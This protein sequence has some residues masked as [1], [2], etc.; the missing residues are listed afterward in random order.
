MMWI[1]GIVCF[2]LGFIIASMLIG[3]YAKENEA[4]KE[5]L[6]Y[7]VMQLRE[8]LRLSQH[9]DAGMG[10]LNPLDEGESKPNWSQHLPPRKYI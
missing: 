2:F 10:R 3:W 4:D 1:V 6:Q 5:R 9:N 7:T 8:E